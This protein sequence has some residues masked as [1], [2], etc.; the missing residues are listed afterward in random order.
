MCLLLV[1]MTNGERVYLNQT[2]GTAVPHINQINMKKQIFNKYVEQ[3]A[4]VYGL[5][6]EEIFKS[7]REA[8]YSDARHMLYYLCKT[9]PM[10]VKQI[11]TYMTERGHSTHH[12]SIIHGVNRVQEM[13][14]SDPDYVTLYTNINLKIKS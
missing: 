11:Q 3:V 9:R 8:K 5:K 1:A 7:S 4:Y 10:S 13:M 12:S 2:R 14:D 6:E